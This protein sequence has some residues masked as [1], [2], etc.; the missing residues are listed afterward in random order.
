MDFIKTS[1]LRA[2]IERLYRESAP[3]PR[4]PAGRGTHVPRSA[5][6]ASVRLK[7]RPKSK[8]TRPITHHDPGNCPRSATPQRHATPRTTKAREPGS[9]ASRP[10]NSLTYHADAPSE[11]GNSRVRPRNHRPNSYP[12][13]TPADRHNIR[14]RPF[15]LGQDPTVRPTVP[16]D[17]PNAAVD[18]K[19][20]LKPNPH[21]SSP[22]PAPT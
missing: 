7:S 4:S 15:R 18:P 10:R 21:N 12:P 5:K 16:T 14:P 22:K 17:R 9:N 2:L 6:A 1:S 11:P 8:T 13:T 19:P 20:F 3:K